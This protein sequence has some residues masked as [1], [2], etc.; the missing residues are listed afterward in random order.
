[1]TDRAEEW[2]QTLRTTGHLAVGLRQR[3]A[4]VFAVVSLLF[5]AVGVAIVLDP[6]DS[7]DVAAGWVTICFFGLCALVLGSIAFGRGPVA[8]GIELDDTGITTPTTR[9]P[10]RWE[11]VEGAQ[12][13]GTRGTHT[14]QLILGGG[15]TVTLPPQLAVDAEAFARWLV[16]EA[17][18]RRGSF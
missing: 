16:A 15:R 3:R 13:R 2:S 6:D 12:V 5:A 10:V 14:V 1:M 17:D 8:G 9:E 4:A 11:E 18:R 7:V